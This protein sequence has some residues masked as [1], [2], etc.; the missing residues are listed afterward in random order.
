M[1]ES[2]GGGLVATTG[3][4]T[5]ASPTGPTG[6]LGL[7]RTKKMALAFDRNDLNKVLDIVATEIGVPIEM[8]GPDFQLAG[9]TKNQSMGLQ[10]P[11]QT[12]D[13]LLQTIL[14]KADMAGR[15][16]Y[17]IKPRNPGE[18]EMIFIA[19]RAGM[20]QRGEKLLPEFEEAADPKKK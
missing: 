10:E 1:I 2:S 12:I 11:E 16:V 17:T 3:G 20:A 14:L 18:E 7:I 4:P 8:V 9:I 5:A 19:T 13:K 15:L 6:V